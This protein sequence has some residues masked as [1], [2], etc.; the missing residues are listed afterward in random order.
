M[1]EE[2]TRKRIEFTNINASWRIIC[3]RVV[4]FRGYNFHFE[5]TKESFMGEKSLLNGR[6]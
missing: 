4:P 6:N 2:I 3:V 5:G 1:E